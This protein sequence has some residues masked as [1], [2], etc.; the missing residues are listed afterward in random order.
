MNTRCV[1]YIGIFLISLCLFLLCGMPVMATSAIKAIDQH[2]LGEGELI[3]DTYFIGKDVYKVNYFFKP[4]PDKVLGQF[5]KETRTAFIQ[6][7]QTE[8]GGSII[9]NGTT[10]ERIISFFKWPVAI[11]TGIILA[12]F[13]WVSTDG[14][15]KKKDRTKAVNRKP[16]VKS[17]VVLMIV[18][19]ALFA[20]SV[21]A[22]TGQRLDFQA[23]LFDNAT[24]TGHVLLVDGK[25]ILIPGKTY[26]QVNLRCGIEDLTLYSGSTDKTGS[27]ILLEVKPTRHLPIYNI[28]SAN[29]YWYDSATY[30]GLGG[31]G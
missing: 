19:V 23:V 4:L 25:E 14:W 1:R 28:D 18:I 8:N 13:L 9:G 27:R 31:N 20:G 17:A 15:F 26:I 11:L 2:A 21:L 30:I 7:I 22:I 16:W 3:T 5:S 10:I 24:S 29:S 12:I 6:K